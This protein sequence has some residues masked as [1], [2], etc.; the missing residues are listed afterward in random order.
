MTELIAVIALIFATS[1]TAVEPGPAA[2]VKQ[3]T[4]LNKPV[5]IGDVVALG[6]F[7]GVINGAWAT[8]EKAF[9][10]GRFRWARAGDGCVD[11]LLEPYVWVAG[12]SSLPL[13]RYVACAKVIPVAG[14]GDRIAFRMPATVL[15]VTGER[16][17]YS[18]A[19]VTLLPEGRSNPNDPM[20]VG[21]ITIKP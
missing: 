18:W 5:L 3:W 17:F 2:T 13:P 1:A 11:V 15:D 16:T 10:Q 21:D 8:S 9:K 7:T 6:S 19:R 14:D 12:G 4:M 20:K